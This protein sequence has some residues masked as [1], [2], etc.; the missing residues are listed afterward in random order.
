MTKNYDITSGLQIREIPTPEIR[1]RVDES[2]QILDIE[3]LVD[4]YLGLLADLNTSSYV[5]AETHR[6]VTDGVA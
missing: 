2:A 4:Q 1:R 5:A 6:A 3:S